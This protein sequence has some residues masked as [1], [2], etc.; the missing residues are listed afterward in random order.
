M[1]RLPLS[2]ALLLAAAAAVGQTGISRYL[3]DAT[4]QML[5]SQGMITRVLKGQDPPVYAPKTAFQNELVKK[6]TGFH[7]TVAVE[8]LRIFRASK[9]PLDTQKGMLSILNAMAS[10]STMKD[11]TYWS[12]TRNKIWTLFTESYAVESPEHPVR[13]ADPAFSTLPDTAR[14]YSFQ[15]DTTFGKNTYETVIHLGTDSLWAEMEN[16]SAVTYLLIPA[17]P[18]KG[19]LTETL[20]VPM[21]DSLLFYGVALLRSSL[22]VGD[23]NSR[24]ESLKNRMVAVSDWLTARLGP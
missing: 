18:A 11:I 7:A 19:L 23:L 17:I 1:R 3:D 20:I 4:I 12:V 6:V 16:L 2:I 8:V 22:P 15:E 14:L 9:R 21:K 24:A 10:T 5:T 13:I